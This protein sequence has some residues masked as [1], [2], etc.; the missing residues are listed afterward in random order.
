MRRARQCPRAIQIS[1]F[2]NP[3]QKKQNCFGVLSPQCKQ[4]YTIRK[5]VRLSAERPRG[6]TSTALGGGWW[7]GWGVPPRQR[8]Y[9]RDSIRP[10]V[11]TAQPKKF[12][13]WNESAGKPR[14][15]LSGANCACESREISHPVWTEPELGSAEKSR[16]RRSHLFGDGGLDGLLRVR[17]GYDGRQH[18]EPLARLEL[19]RQAEDAPVLGLVLRRQFA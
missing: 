4:T 17:S 8:R 1:L 11:F 19:T 13:I 10:P 9:V 5:Q 6:H 12:K 18:R 3:A 15:E 2:Q 14:F 7:W 16:E